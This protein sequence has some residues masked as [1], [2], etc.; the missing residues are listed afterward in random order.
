MHKTKIAQKKDN[1]N[2]QLFG[3][4]SSIIAKLVTPTVSRLRIESADDVTIVKDL[5]LFHNLDAAQA[6]CALTLYDQ[7]A[8]FG[9]S[10]GS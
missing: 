9:D 10:N 7:V 1:I 3:M 5:Q 8:K 2:N 4:M 6:A